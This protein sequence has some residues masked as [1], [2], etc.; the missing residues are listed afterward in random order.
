M[1]A[2]VAPHWL[3]E[4]DSGVE[5]ALHVQPGA[6]RSGVVGEHGGRLKVAVSAPAVDGRANQA[7][8][9]LLAKAC[10][11]PR[12]TVSLVSGAGGR[13]KRVRLAGLTAAQ[14]RACVGPRAIG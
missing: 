1:Q 4:T 5:L 8:L 6:R 14:V 7:L 2:T 12:R 11:V 3:H 9:D 10:G 13:D